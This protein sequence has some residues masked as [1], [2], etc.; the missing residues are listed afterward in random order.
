VAFVGEEGGELAGE[1]LD[2]EAEREGVVG[3]WWEEGDVAGV[4]EDGGGGGGGGREEVGC[5][6]EEG[7]GRER[8]GCVGAFIG[9]EV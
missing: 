6:G 2:V 8:G 3:A 4:E 5:C 9:G 7:E 1:G